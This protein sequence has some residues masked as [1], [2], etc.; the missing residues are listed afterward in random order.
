MASDE[1]EA[2]KTAQ[3]KQPWEPPKLTYIGHVGEIV[4]GG[5]GKLATTGGDFGEVRK[6]QPH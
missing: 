2:G 4:Q 3:S 6:E 5:G 1:S